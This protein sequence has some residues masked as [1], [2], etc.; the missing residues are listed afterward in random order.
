M[1]FSILH[2][3]SLLII[4]ATVPTGLGHLRVTDALYHGLPKSVS[5]V[6]LGAQ[7]RSAESLHRIVSIHPLTR[8]IMEWLQNGPISKTFTEIAKDYLK[9]HTDLLY[10]QMITILGERLIVPKTVLVV[11]THC[12]LA[13][14]IG[15]IKKRL[16]QVTGA[17]IIIV[18]QVTDDSPQPIWYIP[19]ADLIFVPSEYTKTKL[20]IY[21]KKTHQAM[22]PIVVTA[23]PVSPL[24]A[25]ILPETTYKSRRMQLQPDALS[26]IQVS[27]PIPGAAVGTSFLT[28]L[29][30]KLHVQNSRFFFHIVS[31]ETKFTGQFLTQMRKYNYIRLNI[32][33]HD[34][35]TVSNYELLYKHSPLALEITKPSEQSFKALLTP[36]MRGGVILLFSQP[37][38][39]QEYDNLH[40]LRNHG[41]MPS[42]K[43]H[44]HLW[45]LAKKQ[46]PL[47]H[48][49][50]NNILSEAKNWRA[51]RLPDNATDASNF[52]HW[53]LNQYLFLSMFHFQHK[54]N[55]P[56]ELQSNGVEQFWQHT[57]QLL[58]KIHNQ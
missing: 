21:A 22:V 14:Q 37:V 16:E 53:C 34:R 28:K 1:R 45:Q 7:D 30:S 31:K 19:D 18:V 11:A 42:K 50:T 44:E 58:A 13:H 12:S 2:D 8:K 55:L 39:K 15:A 17:K 48:L 40:F 43:I 38:G 10:S 46:H 25:E 47:L 26:A 56:S 5:P 32:S 57:E 9:A 27:I 36:K 33:N 4:L 29:I 51:L 6:L 20:L 49:Q 52:I 23:Y 41:L 24:L 3:N 35:T 54:A